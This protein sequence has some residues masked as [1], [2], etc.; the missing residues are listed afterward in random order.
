MKDPFLA[1]VKVKFNL[2]QDHEGA[3]GEQ[4]YSG[5]ALFSLEPR[6]WMGVGGQRRAPA[7][8]PQGK[9]TGTNCIGGWVG[10]RTGLERCGKA[11]PDLFLR[12]LMVS[13]YYESINGIL[14]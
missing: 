1:K 13:R 3:E 12:Q 5:T 11:Q 2:E 6:R 8:L 7:T 4:R 9:R 10:P 14:T